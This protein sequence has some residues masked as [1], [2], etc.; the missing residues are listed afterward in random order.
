MTA[1]WL[2]I[3]TVLAGLGALVWQSLPEAPAAVDAGSQHI[4]FTLP[5]LNGEQQALPVG[6]VVLLNFW[7]TWC[8]PC[9]KEIPSMV[10]L[11]ERL[12]ASGLKIVAVSVDQRLDDLTGFVKEY[13]M[14][15]Q[16][17]H[18]A[19]SAISHR[20]GVF[21][22]PESFLIDRQGTIIQHYIGAVDWMSAPVLGTIEAMLSKPVASRAT[23][24]AG[25]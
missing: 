19:D 14:P 8:P 17:L 15:F 22:Y 5:D 3:L 16:V 7:A 18:D 6:D 9:R 2:V 10:Q 13:Q 4:T 1:R 21:R 20:Y 24:A 11:H 25:G 23:T 12:A